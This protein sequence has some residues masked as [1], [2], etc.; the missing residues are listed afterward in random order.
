[1]AKKYKFLEPQVTRREMAQ[2]LIKALDRSLTEQ[3][4]K[5][6]HWLGDTEFETRGVLLDLFKELNERIEYFKKD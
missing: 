3:E 2:V 4:I 5:T 6:I 1:M